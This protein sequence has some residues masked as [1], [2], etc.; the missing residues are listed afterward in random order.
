[1]TRDT[2]DR[3][4]LRSI[5]DLASHAAELTLGGPKECPSRPLCGQGLRDR[6]GLEFKTFVALDAG[7]PVTRQALH[8]GAIDVGL[9][10]S[11]DPV[12]DGTNLVALDDDRG[13]QPADNI[14][15][16]VRSEAIE[17]WGPELTATIDG[18][19]AHLTTADVRNLVKAMQSEDPDVA[20]IAADWLKAQDV[21]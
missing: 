1:V 20:A 19:S 21:P 17:R 14:T 8:T 6:Y 4:D 15:P 3:L 9:L 2:A 10:F 13:L 11:T 5:S 7:G 18:V 16:L 12:I